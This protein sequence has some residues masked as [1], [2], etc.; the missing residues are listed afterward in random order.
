MGDEERSSSRLSKIG[1]KENTKKFRIS[2]SEAVEQPRRGDEGYALV[3]DTTRA[4][5]PVRIISYTSLAL[6]T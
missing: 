6:L 3:D 2:R 4:A 1:G 5:P